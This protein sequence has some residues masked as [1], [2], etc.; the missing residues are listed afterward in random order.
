MSWKRALVLSGSVLLAGCEGVPQPRPGSEPFRG[1]FPAYDYSGWRQ[2]QVQQ[3]V[4]PHQRFRDFR[5]RF[6]GGDVHVKR[7][8]GRIMLEMGGDVLFALNSAEL[9]V[10]A[11]ATIAMIAD[12]LERSPYGEIEVN[13][14]TDTSGTDAHNNALSEARANAVADE[15]ARDGVDPQRIVGRGL[16]ESNLK[17]PTP[18]GVREPANRRVEI[19]IEPEA[20][21][22]PEPQRGPGFGPRRGLGFGPRPGYGPQQGY[23]PGPGPGPQPGYGQPGYGQPDYGPP[24]DYDRNYGPPQGYEPPPGYGPEPPPENGYQPQHGPRVLPGPGEP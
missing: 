8:Q 24:P 14:Y 18:D 5:R 22:A 4:V 1:E 21:Q 6:R 9:R 2:V 23:G 12:E 3:P 11:R 20:G 19:V 16:G 15:L 7:D 10:E 13:G 17:V